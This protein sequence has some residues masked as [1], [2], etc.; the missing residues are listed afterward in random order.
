MF[1]LD[2]FTLIVRIIVL[3]TTIPVHEAAHAWVADRLGDPT[4]RYMGRLTLN[5]TAHFDLMGSIALVFIG[6]GWAKPVPVN[7]INFDNSK[8]GMAITAAAGPVSNLLLAFVSLVFAKILLYFGILTGFGYVTETLYTVFSVMCTTNISLA[9]FNLMP[10]PPF[11]GSRIF[12]Y[13]LS[14][15]LYFKIMQYE[16]YIFMAVFVLLMIGVFDIPLGFL[17]GIV[18]FVLNKLTFFVDLIFRIIV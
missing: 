15:R 10:F 13:F 2:P 17:N 5:P 12:N 4:G 18:Y 7:P 3:I 8:K 1:R 14:D 9:I 11:D 6:I 16:Q